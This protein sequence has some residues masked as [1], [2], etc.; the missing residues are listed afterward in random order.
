MRSAVDTN[1]LLDILL[2]SPR[3][4]VASREILRRTS[5]EGALVA[6][7]IVWAETRAHFRSARA[8]ESAL[9][10]LGVAFDTSDA[11]VAALAGEAWRTYRHS[12]GRRTALTPDFLVAAHAALR[13]DRLV[14][15][16]RGF[17]RRYFR[18]LTILDPT[19]PARP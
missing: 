2:P 5:G 12:G 14:T 9:E 11:E 7:D 10:T 8:F 6:C 3:F 19:S 18:R 16:D 4:G 15:R 13:A 1:V 17:A